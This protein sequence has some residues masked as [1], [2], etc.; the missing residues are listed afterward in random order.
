[1]DLEIPE[2][3][4]IARFWDFWFID[5]ISLFLY[6]LILMHPLNKTATQTLR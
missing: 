1:M 6:T 3:C 5:F 2:M 4:L